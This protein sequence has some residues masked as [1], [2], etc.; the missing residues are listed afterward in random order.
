[1]TDQEAMQTAMIAFQSPEER[2]F[3]DAVRRLHEIGYGRMMQIISTEWVRTT[4]RP[5][6][7]SRAMTEGEFQH[8]Q[9]LAENDPL[10]GPWEPE[11]INAARKAYREMLDGLEDPKS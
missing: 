3:L 4:G 1:M 5:A 7:T 8:A 6:Y 11:K 10:F 9:W 2:E